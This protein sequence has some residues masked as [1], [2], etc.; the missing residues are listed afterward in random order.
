MRAAKIEQI[1]YEYVG[2][3]SISDSEK[4]KEAENYFIDFFSR[5][6]Y[7][8]RNKEHYGRFPIF[9]DPHERAVAW[10][11]VKGKGSSAVVLIHHNDVVTV[12]DFKSLKEYAFCPQKLEKELFK[13]KEN[14]SKEA[15][16]DLESGNY[17]FGRGVCDMKGGGA[18][19]MALLSEYAEREDFSGNV[20]LLALPDEENL[21]AGMRAAV[22]LLNELKEI[23]KFDYKLMINSEP[24]QRK[25]RKKGIFSF[26]SIGKLMPYVYVRGFLA[27]A[28]KVFEG[29]NPANIMAEIVRNTEVNM[30]F[31]DVVK[32]E[33]SPP[34]TW[35]YLRENKENYDVS[36]PLSVQG[37]LSVLTLN[38]TPKSILS[39]LKDICFASFE[40]VLE[41]MNRN[42][43]LFLKATKQEE[44]DLMWKPK[45]VEFG[46][47]YREAQIRYG[48]KFVE[49][50]DRFLE[51]L[52]R[53][54]HS[55]E[56]SLITANFHLV[57]FV[58]DFI[59]DLSP[60]VVIGLVPPYYPNVSN[61]FR[62]NQER[63]IVD[64][65]DVLSDFVQRKYEQRYTQE[66]FYTGISD[67]SYSDVHNIDESI[68]SLK[69]AMP[70]WGKI[71][72]LPIYD[73]QR[74]SMPCVNIGPWGKD[75]HKL[76]ERVYKE[77]VFERTPA[78]VDYAVKFILE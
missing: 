4:E 64:L 50:Y 11:M 60:R 39:K 17:L 37:C 19:Q 61:F 56:E 48:E 78:I 9:D 55:N 71:Y 10:A 26:G 45:V 22:I 75:F 57:E 76:T 1:L 68:E 29:L 5:Q 25:D 14:L 38:Q 62:E 34:P 73:I 2:R 8:Q 53:K 42:Y 24:H 47:L 36:M 30:E 32:G 40:K 31:S 72:N 23:H 16:E 65:Y 51:D 43:R 6:E 13:M 63:K 20:I 27:H 12:E 70:F 66:Y 58:Y 77:D 3:E 69:N 21:S 7:F 46:E 33:A 59:D 74:I 67:L 44:K 52:Y 15:R 54:I 28:G 35:L 41:E 49:E 18:V